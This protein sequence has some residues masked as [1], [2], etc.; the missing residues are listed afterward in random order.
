VVTLV[1]RR[2]SILEYCQNVLFTENIL[3]ELARP[4]SVQTAHQLFQRLAIGFLN[5]IHDCIGKHFW[6]WRVRKWSSLGQGKSSFPTYVR[7][8]FGL[9][10]YFAIANIIAVHEDVEYNSIVHVTIEIVE[11]KSFLVLTKILNAN[12]EREARIN[13][14]LGK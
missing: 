13:N 3:A 14:R 7:A 10:A 6:F 2:P 11:N 9:E 5:L 1:H 8:S 12:L 4:L